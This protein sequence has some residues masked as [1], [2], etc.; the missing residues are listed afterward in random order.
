MCEVILEGGHQGG[1]QRTSRLSFSL[2]N[3]G[4][5]TAPRVQTG[6]REKI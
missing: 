6:G 4:Q 3:I 1:S 2:E 5:C